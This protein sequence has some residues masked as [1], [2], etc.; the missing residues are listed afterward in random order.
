MEQGAARCVAPRFERPKQLA[1]SHD[2]EVSDGACTC[3]CGHASGRWRLLH[4][5]SRRGKQA[6]SFVSYA[7]DSATKRGYVY[8]PGKHD[9]NYWLNVGTI[10][11]GLEGNWFQSWNAWDE[12]ATPLIKAATSR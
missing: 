10:F 8:P 3:S 2:V 6:K 12:V 7:L 5:C 1:N 11:R 4:T 9:E